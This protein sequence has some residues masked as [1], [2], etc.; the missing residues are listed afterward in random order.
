[1]LDKEPFGLKVLAK[2]NKLLRYKKVPL[3]AVRTNSTHS[4]QAQMLTAI[5]G[6]IGLGWDGIDGLLN[7]P[8]LSAQPCGVDKRAYKRKEDGHVSYLQSF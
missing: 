3:T 1:M 8:L 2:R 7:A 5:S 4:I 6:W